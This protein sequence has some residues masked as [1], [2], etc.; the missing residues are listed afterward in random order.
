MILGETMGGINGG[1]NRI[2][3]DMSSGVPE[4]KNQRV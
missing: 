4:G 1:E 3:E 2:G